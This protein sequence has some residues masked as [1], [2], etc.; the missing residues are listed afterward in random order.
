MSQMD[1]N[2]N[3]HPH[4]CALTAVFATCSATTIINNDPALLQLFGQLGHRSS[5]HPYHAPHFRHFTSEHTQLCGGHR[6]CSAYRRRLSLVARRY[7]FFLFLSS[8]TFTAAHDL[9]YFLTLSL[10]S[11]QKLSL[12][13]KPFTKCLKYTN[14]ALSFVASRSCIR[15]TLTFRSVC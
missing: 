4:R 7:V 10:L 14:L 2:R 15:H 5:D 6:L 1:D 9:G 8:D 3:Q 11:I 13:T 12:F